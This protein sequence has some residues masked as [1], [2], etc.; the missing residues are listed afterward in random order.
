ME[1]ENQGFVKNFVNGLK[2]A[3]IYTAL[4]TAVVVTL[5]A[6]D[7]NKTPEPT[8]APAPDI[9]DTPDT[10]EPEKPSYEYGTDTLAI[11][12]I[13]SQ[14]E[15][16]KILDILG[17]K[18]KNVVYISNDLTHEQ[19]YNIGT[20]EFNA[21][22]DLDLLNSIEETDIYVSLIANTRSISYNELT[23]EEFLY[24]YNNLKIS[25]GVVNVSQ[26]HSNINYNNEGYSIIISN[27]TSVKDLLSIN[28]LFANINEQKRISEEGAHPQIYG[29][30]E[31]FKK[32][33]G[34]GGGRMV[35]TDNKT[36][37]ETLPDILGN[38]FY[39]TSIPVVVQDGVE[40]STKKENTIEEQQ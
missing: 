34:L 30:I 33:L 39:N 8:P 29:T 18:Y 24:I 7:L 26:Y 6:C 28:E 25:R 15:L 12:N 3:A 9:P 31:E 37:Y 40:Y 19:A 35:F 14:E 22:L 10:P 16:N 21:Y 17:D 11:N 2:K 36:P 38:E 5:M 4:G 23:L 20:N 27:L 32:Q 13:K 1:K